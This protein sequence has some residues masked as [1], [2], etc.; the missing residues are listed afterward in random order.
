VTITHPIFLKPEDKPTVVTQTTS[1]AVFVACSATKRDTRSPAWKL[2]DSTLFEKSW[3]AAQMLGQPYVISAKHG[4]VPPMKRL[5]PYDETLKTKSSAEANSWADGVWKTLP[6]Q[7][8]T[9]VILGGRDYVVPLKRTHDGPFS[10]P[11][12]TIHDP[13]E[14]TSGN[15]QQMAVAGELAWT[16]VGTRSVSEAITVAQT[17]ALE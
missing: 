12:V 4:L 8:D 10:T 7:Y 16:A 3:T 14:P 1:T 15:G 9:V 11:T 5:E 17:E 2:Y 13:Y 6:E